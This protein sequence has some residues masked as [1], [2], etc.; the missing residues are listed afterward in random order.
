M[1]VKMVSMR[2]VL[3][4]ALLLAAGCRK[5]TEVVLRLEAASG[6]PSVITVRLQRSKPFNDNP[7][8]T[9]GF[10]V[11]QLNGADL[12]L[13][14]TPQGSSTVLSL[15]PAKGAPADLRVAVSAAGFKVEPADP[16]ETA[17]VEGESRELRFTLDELP[18]PP[19]LWGVRD[20]ASPPADVATGDDAGADGAAGD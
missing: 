4:A 20:L 10:V 5:A 7:M 19:D 15:L 18:R 9:P 14:V 1:I 6:T 16:Q 17:F 8:G 12:E 2:T 11:A 3:L 13:L